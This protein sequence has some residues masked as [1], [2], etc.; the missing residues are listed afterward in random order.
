[1]RIWEGEEPNR[2]IKNLLCDFCGKE[3]DRQTV[4]E[5]LCAFPFIRLWF[6]WNAESVIDADICIP[7]IREKIAPLTLIEKESLK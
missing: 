3:I 5:G 4:V 1:M 6:V 7:C 2:S